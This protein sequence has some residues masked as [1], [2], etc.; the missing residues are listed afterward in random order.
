MDANGEIDGVCVSIAN[1]TSKKLAEEQIKETADQLTN[2][3]ETISDGMFILNNDLTV[4]YMNRSA[5]ELLQVDR[6]QLCWQHKNEVLAYFGASADSPETTFHYIDRAIEKGKMISF[7]E[8]YRELHLWFEG[9]IYP[10]GGGVTIYFRDITER[11]TTGHDAP[12]G[13]RSVGNECDS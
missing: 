7:T 3:M 8:Y 10:I 6:E 2:I 1:I 4:K 12:P 9:E 11:K 5:E 13:E